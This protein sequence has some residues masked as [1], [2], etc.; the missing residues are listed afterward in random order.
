[1]KLMQVM[2]LRAINEIKSYFLGTNIYAFGGGTK[3]TL[4]LKNLTEQYLE[5]IND[6]SF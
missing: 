3:I 2:K 1:M 5:Y 6:R 4:V